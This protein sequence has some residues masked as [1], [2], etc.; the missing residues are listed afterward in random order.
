MLRIAGVLVCVLLTLSLGATVGAR[1][2][3]TVLL[4]TGS[5]WIY[6]YSEQLI[7]SVTVFANPG[8]VDVYLAIEGTWIIECVGLADPAEGSNTPTLEFISS[9]SANVSGSAVF[10]D[11]M[12]MGS[13][14]YSVEGSLRVTGHEFYNLTTGMPV[15]T[16]YD[17]RLE[18][19]S[20]VGNQFK[21]IVY[22]TEHNETTFTKIELNSFG[23][24]IDPG[25]TN[26]A[27]GDHWSLVY[28]ERCN[29]TGVD[30]MNLFSFKS[31]VNETWD[32]TYLGSQSITVP[33]G[34]FACK[35]VNGTSAAYSYTEWYNRDIENDVKVVTSWEGD[36]STSS[37]TSYTIKHELMDLEESPRFNLE[38][39]MIGLVASIM[40]VVVIPS[41][42]LWI[43]GHPPER[44]GP[45]R[46]QWDSP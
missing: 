29:S 34:V 17:Q 14:R 6:D 40:A 3:G 43:T 5:V 12:G 38:F 10:W 19:G 9:I 37:L 25:Y 31:G 45:E 20:F 23:K 36:V 27:P 32:F 8:P 33:A 28:Q 35:M 41:M 44:Q 30:Q 11:Y 42:Y 24:E 15:R 18:V 21:S 1:A 7:A 46:Q 16:V 4:P 39:F 26:L 13:Q 2:A 22:Y